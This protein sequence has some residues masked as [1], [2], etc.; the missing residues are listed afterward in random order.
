VGFGGGGAAGYSFA[1]R[2]RSSGGASSSGKGVAV[3]GQR[4]SDASTIGGDSP[5]TTPASPS[6]SR[7]LAALR[8]GRYETAAT[9]LSR[10]V[11]QNPDDAAAHYYLG[12]AYYLMAEEQP[13]KR[14]LARKAAAEIQEA[15]RLR[16]DFTP[17]WKKDGADR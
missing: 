7:G 11:E 6:L 13:D 16:P 8:T 12:Y 2:P 5:R 17:N 15:Y 10:A 3:R 14:E 9:E 4:P 1:A